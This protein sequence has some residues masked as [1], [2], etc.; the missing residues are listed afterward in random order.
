M[1]ISMKK[2]FAA[3]AFVAATLFGG[4]VVSSAQAFEPNASESLSDESSTDFVSYASGGGGSCDH[5]CDDCGCDTKLLGFIRPSDQC[6][7]DF[8]S[9]MTNP[10]YFED[11]RTLSELRFIFVN[12]TL[13][14]RAP[15]VG[16]NVQLFAMQIRAALTDRLSIIATKDGFFTTGADP[17]IMKDGWADVNLG[18]KYNLYADPDSQQLLS[19]GARY[20]LPVGTPRALQGNGDGVF[21]FF[22]TGG[23]AFGTYGHWISGAGFWIPVDSAAESQAF[24]WSNHWDWQINGG[25]WYALTEV[26]WYHWMKS[27]KGG[28]AGLEGLDVINLGS[29]GV[30]GNDIVTGAIGAKYKHSAYSEIGV[31]WEAPLTDR[32]DILQNRLTIDWIVRY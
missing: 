22:L 3:V 14:T 7:V 32:R 4:V 15:L 9:P 31:A 25:K 26:N 24:Y 2:W 1:R 20:E 19:V 18:L 6:F 13:P 5:E 12:H 21:D 17:V 30:A 27:G 16:G 10:V 28:V 8:I 29:T 11:P 23:A